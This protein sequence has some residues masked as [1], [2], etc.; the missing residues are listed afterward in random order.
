MA[1]ADKCFFFDWGGREIKLEDFDCYNSVTVRKRW[2]ENSG[3][4]VSV[5]LWGKQKEGSDESFE[6]REIVM[7][8]D[9]AMVLVTKL[10]RAVAELD[11][12]EYL[13][14]IRQYIEF[15]QKVVDKKKLQEVERRRANVL[16]GVQNGL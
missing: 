12:D 15:L 7:T 16:K 5:E 4:C 9:N 13:S 3:N 11:A 10:M 2:I 6:D 8:R 14:D 1:Y